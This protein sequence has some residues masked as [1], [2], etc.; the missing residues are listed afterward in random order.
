MERRIGFK[1]CVV[2]AREYKICPKCE[3][4][5]GK[6]ILSWKYTCDTPECFQIFMVL[7]G[8]AD[9]EYT[10]EKA[11]E[12]LNSLGVDKLPS[13]EENAKVLIDEIMYEEP[14]VENQKVS[15]NTNTQ[16][17]LNKFVK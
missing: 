13:L 12:L 17:Y 1:Y 4:L 7:K 8:Y 5:A 11:K 16:K 14:I 2:C 15:N 10:K 9:K 3:Q 6:Q